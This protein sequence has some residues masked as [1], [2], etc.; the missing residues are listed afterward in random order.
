[1]AESRARERSLKETHEMEIRK[2]E[3]AIIASKSDNRSKSRKAVQR[4]QSRSKS[5]LASGKFL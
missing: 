1:M 5:K 3:A 2:K 4:E